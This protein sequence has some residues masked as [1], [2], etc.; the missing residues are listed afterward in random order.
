MNVIKTKIE[1]ARKETDTKLSEKQKESGNYKKGHINV[2]GFKISLENPKGSYRSGVDKKGK[3][4]KIK[5]KN[6]YGY[7]LNTIGYDGDHIDCFLGSDIDSKKIFV[8]DQKNNGKFD[9]SKVMLWFN[10]SE[11]A[12]KAYLSNYESNWKGFDKIT[13]VDEEF[14]KKWLYDGKKQRKPFSEYNIIKNTKKIKIKESQLRN[15]IQEAVI[16][17]LNETSAKKNV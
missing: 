12:K 14:F 1:K 5:M 2:N 17:V 10:D 4:W 3:Q 6:D 8:I 16:R 11:S 15:M 13:E 7:F 9:E